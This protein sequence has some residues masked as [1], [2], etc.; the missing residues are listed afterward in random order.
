MD[1]IAIR[2]APSGLFPTPFFIGMRSV[3]HSL[4]ISIVLDDAEVSVVWKKARLVDENLNVLATL[5]QE[6]LDFWVPER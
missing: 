1:L 6:D 4:K 5:I 3:H 2:Q